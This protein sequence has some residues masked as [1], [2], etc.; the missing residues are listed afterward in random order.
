ME[1]FNLK[2]L[3]DVDVKRRVKFQ[4]LN[5]FSALE[6]LDDSADNKRAW[7]TIKEDIKTDKESL[8][9]CKL[10]L[11]NQGYKLS[12]QMMQAKLL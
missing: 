12:N 9:R 7:E 6:C 5:T 3:N 10:N 8:V 4:I 1:R 11:K 2:N